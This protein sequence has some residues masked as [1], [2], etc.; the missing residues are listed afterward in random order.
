MELRIFRS[1]P[2]PWKLYG[3]VPEDYVVQEEAIYGNASFNDY[4]EL[5]LWD[6]PSKMLK[7]LSLGGNIS[8]TYHVPNNT[9]SVIRFPYLESFACYHCIIDKNIVANFPWIFS[10]VKTLYLQTRQ[11]IDITPWLKLMVNLDKVFLAPGSFYHIA[12]N[13]VGLEL[14]PGITNVYQYN[15]HTNRY[16]QVVLERN[17]MRISRVW[18]I[19]PISTR[20]WER[21]KYVEVGRENFWTSWYEYEAKAT[22][23]PLDLN[24]QISEHYVFDGSIAEAGSFKIMPSIPPLVYAKL[25]SIT[26]RNAKVIP[27]VLV[28]SVAPKGVL[29]SLVLENVKL[30]GIFSSKLLGIGRLEEFRLIRTSYFP[31]YISTFDSMSMETF[32]S[33]VPIEIPLYHIR[34]LF[35]P[36]SD[37][38]NI[39]RWP[40][41]KV[42]ELNYYGCV[43]FYM[44]RNQGELIL[45]VEFGFKLVTSLANVKKYDITQLR[46]LQC[47]NLT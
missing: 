45:G 10:T 13:Y 21:F 38:G 26:V 2:Y 5:N 18:T 29:R 3:A 42:F 33:M 1:N 19:R 25:K 31:S 32:Y 27:E 37:L 39:Y 11:I 9:S 12:G 44:N 16:G 8:L 23:L 22:L 7:H 20:Y 6:I 4:Q 24:A 41:L 43:P 40:S 47:L 30:L 15:D 46:N 34:G 36:N 35:I 17:N 28:Q 14:L